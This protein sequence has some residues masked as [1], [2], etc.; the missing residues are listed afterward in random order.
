[1]SSEQRSNT[2]RNNTKVYGAIAAFLLVVVVVCAL[3]VNRKSPGLS[4][5]NIADF[6]EE[7]PAPQAIIRFE[8]NGRT[9]FG[10]VAE[11][12]S[13]DKLTV[14]SGPPVYVFDDSRAMVDYTIDVGD[15]PTF[16][17]N[18]EPLMTFFRN[19]ENYVTLD[20]VTP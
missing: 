20:A 16:V 17:K 12:S 1:M 6:A 3:E 8:K 19:E 14:P 15:D 13:L 11:L 5:V 10:W 4:N 18:W 7:K 2:K 9:Y